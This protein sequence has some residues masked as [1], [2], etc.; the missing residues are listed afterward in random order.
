MKTKAFILK[1]AKENG[2]IRSTDVVRERHI[3]RQSAAKALSEL[4]NEGFL[5]KS[6]S[7]RN[8]SYLFIEGRQSAHQEKLRSRPVVHSFK[9][10]GL[11]EDRVF[12]AISHEVNMRSELSRNAFGIANYAFCEMLNNAIDHSKADTV[13]VVFGFQKERFYFEV[14]DEGI[15]AFNSIQQKFNLQNRLESIEHLLKGKQTTMPDKH[16][17]EGIFYTSKI[18]DAF[19]LENAEERLIIDNKI[20]DVFVEK[21]SFLQGTRVTFFCI[22]NLAEN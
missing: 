9:I 4:V 10:N 5:L 20:D 21:M 14:I 7:T 12:A 3:S 16:S 8:A 1:Y 22:K 18:A 2:I 11:N 6:G 15:G 17:G 19:I 13:K